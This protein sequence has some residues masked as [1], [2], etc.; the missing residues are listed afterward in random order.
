MKLLLPAIGQTI[1]Y[2]TSALTMDPMG[3][4][5]ELFQQRFVLL[6]P[7]QQPRFQGS[8]PLVPGNDVAMTTHNDFCLKHE[9]VEE[10][11]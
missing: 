1:G 11:G 9:L 4:W 10:V 2:L 3:S 8:L 7:R 5:S 6:V